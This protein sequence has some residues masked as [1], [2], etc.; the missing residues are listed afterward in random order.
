MCLILVG[1]AVTLA[2]PHKIAATSPSQAAPGIQHL[3]PGEPIERDLAGGQ[4]HSYLIKAPAAQYMWITVE[5]KRINAVVSAFDPAGKK[6]FEADIFGVGDT[7]SV[8]AIAETSG[9]YRVEVRSSDKTASPG[10]YRITLKELRP[11]TDKDRKFAGAMT[12]VA[13]AV[14]LYR[15][16]TPDSNP[17]AVET[18]DQAIPLLHAIDQVAW[19]A[20]A[21]YL[22]GKVYI[23]L[24]DKQK[25]LDYANRALP[26]AQAA[27]N[28]P[29]EQERREGIQLLAN[30]IDTI[31]LVYN[32]FGDKKKALE[33]SNQALPLRRQLG[34]RTGELATLNY[35]GMAHGYMGEYRQA[36]AFF[37]Q[38]RAI[39]LELGDRSTDATVL[40][41]MCVVNSS[42]G[43]YNKALAA[44]NQALDIRRAQSSL[45]G[46]A[47]VLDN[48][49]TVHSSRGEYQQALDFHNQVLAIYR[50]QR[51]RHGEGIS[52]NNIAWIYSTLGE[53]QRA[54]DIY[55]QAIDIFRSLG[56][57]YREALTL[58]NVAV[59]HAKMG[60]YR[61]ALELHQQLLPIRQE[62]ADHEGEAITLNQIAN[63]YEH[64]GEKQKVLPYYEQALA[65]FRTIGKE[66][67]LI[68]TLNYMGRYYRDSGQPQKAMDYF[69]EGLQVSRTIGDLD[70]EAR[71][72]ADVAQ[73]ELD[74][75]NLAEART[76]IEAGLAAI[77]S[78][79]F[80][81]KRYDL[82]ASFLASVRQFYELDVDILMRLHRQRPTEGFDAAAFHA[83]EQ[84]R[85][86]SLLDLLSEAN[87]EIRK[88]VDATLLDRERTLR[89]LI[90]EKAE[91]QMRASGETQSQVRA[92]GPAREGPISAEEAQ[93]S[94]KAMAAKEA[95]ETDDLA[96]EYEQ[97]QAQI[98]Q[99]SPRYAA[100]TQPSPLTAKQIQTDLLDPDTMLLEYSL[101]ELKSFLWALTSTGI[102]SFDLPA[103]DEIESAVRRS[104]SILTE[105]NRTVPG[106]T[107]DQ[108]RIRVQQADAEYP[109]SAA[110]LGRMLLGAVAADL[111]N[112]R[113]L[114]VG[115]GALQYLPFAALPEPLLPGPES[116]PQTAS[117]Q[118]SQSAG[119]PGAVAPPEGSDK[120]PLVAQHEI[121]IL[122]SASVLAV[123][124]RESAG[125]AGAEK[126]VAVF[127]DPVFSADDPRVKG[128]G[129]PAAPA[130]KAITRPDNATAT[131]AKATAAKTTAGPDQVE[132]GTDAVRSA[133][134]SG[135][136]GLVRLRFSRREADQIAR[137]ASEG[138]KLEA[139]DF[140]A[141]R[142]AATSP[143]LA[144]YS[145]LHFA[146]HG[147]INS[148]HPEL[149]GVVLSLVD[150]SGRPQNGYL[151][152]Y[153]IYNL[154]LDAG[155]VVLS[156]CQTALGKDIKGEGL[157]GLTR[158]FMYAGA[159]RVV[160]SLWQVDDRATADLME[161]FYEAML[162]QGSRPAAAL[163]SAQLSA[164][165]DK[166]WQSPYYW[167]AFTLQ[168][169]WK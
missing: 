158:G 62:V 136:T 125:R 105:R 94:A 112:K 130:D 111:K 101:G 160:A 97:V 13:S 88:D 77:E 78:L 35:I 117:Q 79:R 122:P 162:R 66:R 127:A 95:R 87:A 47:L 82:R 41:N 109:K 121:I 107:M 148:Q 91:Q 17:K 99:K 102:K 42:L 34:D 100:L 61:K 22:T 169:E 14:S 106:E 48:I 132:P 71:I 75:G 23:S 53:N 74:R 116:G 70:G 26:I 143:D 28:R 69:N 123:L 129:A 135:L 149:S 152:L 166:R 146:T 83:S 51:N 2:T 39:A 81:V 119:K 4:S 25:A 44:C 20:T 92:E 73:L 165:K 118:A 96:T 147:L 64:L 141:N 52:L 31:G 126:T 86:R 18:F 93:T 114:I 57:R 8:W 59:N 150:E 153:D 15:Q 104:Y 140:A 9:D 30:V 11:A 72:L 65:M 115:E 3:E 120:M 54:I 124:R 145:I 139:V 56:D 133:T 27:A 37:E 168:G 32:T 103:R 68:T 159:P 63:C 89:Q 43:E 24:A 49:G 55:N 155:L 12:L 7:E 76:R 50:E 46:Q 33:L 134:E 157:I 1:S 90:S 151:R 156:A 128:A 38:A 58:T 10:S 167:A 98:R 6:I 113:L 67:H 16:N 85:A 21:L 137:L 163:R 154:K 40:N 19:E 80:N 36:L 142:T 29:G 45:L 5:Q 60:E 108:R 164:L 84:G 161:R 138:K 131:P 144:H 110:A